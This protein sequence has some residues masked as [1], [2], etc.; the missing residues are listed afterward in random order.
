MRCTVHEYII[1]LHR[2]H[3]DD[4]RKW[5]KKRNKSLFLFH[6]MC[7]RMMIKYECYACTSYTAQHNKTM[8]E[9]CCAV[10]PDRWGRICGLFDNAIE[11]AKKEASSTET[12]LPLLLLMPLMMQFARVN[13]ERQCCGFECTSV[14]LSKLIA[15][16]AAC[17]SFTFHVLPHSFRN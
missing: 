2:E 13:D 6:F 10:A 7:A 4:G 15:M 1:R 14:Y 17:A 8:H 3:D 16:L 11:S 12:V 9:S 5:C